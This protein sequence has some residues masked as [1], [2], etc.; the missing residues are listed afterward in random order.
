MSESIPSPPETPAR[1]H[2]R[3]LWEHT[4]FLKLWTGQTIS[5]FGSLLSRIAIPFA[6]ALTLHAT[7]AQMA[8]LGVADVI[9]S[10]LV[11]PF[12]GVWADR[13]RRR[14]LMIAADLLRAAVLVAIPL[15]A[16]RGTLRIEHLYLAGLLTGMLNAL[17]DVAYGAYLPTLVGVDRLAEGNAK[18]SATA[19]VAEFTAFSAA[20]WLV[21]WFG[22][23][24]ALAPAV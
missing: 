3:G 22:G 19:S 17:F 13:T 16:S 2:N 23:E 18:L 7:P 24:V 10:L 4:D 12:A 5:I 8:L 20:G 9:P 6:A 11:G 15:V 1:S 21:Q 14:P